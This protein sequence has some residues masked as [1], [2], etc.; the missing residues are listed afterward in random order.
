MTYQA[1]GTRAEFF[2]LAS[3]LLGNIFG[4]VQHVNAKLRATA[5]PVDPSTENPATAQQHP[6]DFAEYLRALVERMTK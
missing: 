6:I 1:L 5:Q 4:A 3:Q 2:T